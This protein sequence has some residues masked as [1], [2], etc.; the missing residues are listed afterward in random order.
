MEQTTRDKYWKVWD[1]AQQDPEYRRMLEQMRDVEL[2]Y[3]QVLQTLDRDGQDKVCEFVSL[4]E[5]MS[6]RM[7]EVALE[8]YLVSEKA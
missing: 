2:Q 8:Q 5:A 1:M 4:C 7:L 6:E 3:D